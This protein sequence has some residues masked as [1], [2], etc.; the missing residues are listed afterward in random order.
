[1]SPLFCSAISW[2]IC[3]S[4]ALPSSRVYNKPTP[5]HTN[6]N[7]IVNSIVRFK[8]PL[9]IIG[10]FGDDFMGQMIQTTVSMDSG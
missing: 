10:H 1:M 5:V 7:S 4:N 6:I 2:D 9:H 8:F 3:R